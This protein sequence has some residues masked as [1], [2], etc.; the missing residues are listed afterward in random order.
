MDCRPVRLVEY[1][2]VLAA[3]TDARTAIG[4]AGVLLLA[5]P[6]LL[7]CKDEQQP[8]AAEPGEPAPTT[9]TT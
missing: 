2:G 4:L 3:V 8:G 5:T 6:L 7:P 9:T 1:G